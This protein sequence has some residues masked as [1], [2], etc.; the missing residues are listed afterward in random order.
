MISSAHQTS[1]DVFSLLEKNSVLKSFLPIAG[2]AVELELNKESNSLQIKNNAEKGQLY[3]FLPLDVCADFK[4]HIN[5]C[6]FITEDRKHLF[7]SSKDSADAFKCQWNSEVLM[8]PLVASVINAMEDFATHFNL[9]SESTIKNLWPVNQNSVIFKKFEELFYKTIVDSNSQ[10]FYDNLFRKS[11]QISACKFVNF[12]LSSKQLNKS[13]VEILRKSVFSTE[14]LII[15][16]DATYVT[17]LRTYQSQKGNFISNVDLVRLL[18]DNRNKIQR[19]DFNQLILD[20]LVTKA[21]E[22]YSIT[23]IGQIIKSCECI[24][25]TNGKLS[26]ISSLLDVNEQLISLFDDCDGVFPAQFYQNSQDAMFNLKKLGLTGS[27]KLPQMI[28]RAHSI[29]ELSSKD[30]PKAQKRSLIIFKLIENQNISTE[31]AIT[32]RSIEF[33]FAK[34]CRNNNREN[35]A[36]LQKSNF[37][38]K[39][40]CVQDLFPERLENLIGAVCPIFDSALNGHS[41][42][43]SKDIQPDLVSA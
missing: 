40:F 2:I 31:H 25:S 27:I 9:P 32:V 24:E 19:D 17:K 22:F 37:E 30:L 6:F 10:L 36:D 26:S 8:K 23:E 12:D 29:K 13:A 4:F 15:D 34:K 14:F 16:I 39:P 11:Y 7:E 21:I 35:F 43:I 42:F 5:G 20:F 38:G 41:E 33:I 3:C 1:S 18:I 28:E